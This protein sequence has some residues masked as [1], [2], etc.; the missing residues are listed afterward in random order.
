M[1]LYV[2]S[3]GAGPDLVLLHG[4]GLHG[5]VWSSVIEILAKRFRVHAFDLPGHGYSSFIPFGGL[6]D[7]ANR[8]A[9]VIPMG[10]VVCGWS[11]GGLIAQRL[12]LRHPARVRALALVS[13]TPCFLVR[14]DWPHAMK[15]EILTGFAAGLRTDFNATLKTFVALNALGGASTRETIRRLAD[16]ML[17]R[18]VP[19]PSAL[20]AGLAMLQETDLRTEVRALAQKTVV[21]HGARDALA[22]VEAGRWLAANLR[23]A[24]L[25][26]FEDAAHL[27]FISHPDAFAAALDP[28][29][30]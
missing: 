18:G 26:E 9:N 1:N 6:D 20:D 27:P 7:A 21:I 14:D 23:S 30:G 10:T 25:V 2:K 17:S 11:M 22:P 16:E 8:L 4:W 15:S 29:H 12:A 3:I 13:T 28:L 19:D 24:S 5:G